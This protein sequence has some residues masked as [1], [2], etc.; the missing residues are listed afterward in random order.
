MTANP[1]A[2]NA[3]RSAAWTLCA[4]LALLA[5][6]PAAADPY[7]AGHLV[8]TEVVASGGVSARGSLELLHVARLAGVGTTPSFEAEGAT[9]EWTEGATEGLAIRAPG[10][11]SAHT[12]GL[13]NPDNVTG[14]PDRFLRHHAT[15]ESGEVQ[16]QYLVHLY[17]A[18]ALRYSATTSRLDTTTIETAHFNRVDGIRSWQPKDPEHQDDPAYDFKEFKVP[19]AVTRSVAT[20]S[21]QITVH[22]TFVVE[23]MGVS[24]VIDGDE[25]KRSV[26]SGTRADP[27]APGAP[28]DNAYNE[29]RTFIRMWVRDGSATFGSLT[30][31]TQWA[32]PATSVTA[33]SAT[34]HAATGTLDTPTGETLEV[35]SAR[36]TIGSMHDLAMRPEEGA[37]G[38]DVTGLD[39]EGH[40]LPPAGVAA[41]PI[42]ASFVGAVFLVLAGLAAIAVGAWALRRR[43]R[44]EPTLAEVEAALAGGQYRKAARDAALILHRKPGMETAMISRAIALSKAGRNERVVAE[45]EGHLRQSDPSDGVLH[46]VLGVAYSDLGRATQAQAAF[47]EALARTPSLLPEVRARLPTGSRSPAPSSKSPAET[48]GYA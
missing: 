6:S 38:V 43:L 31:D 45:V 23:I 15:F 12:A 47:E 18:S 5:V 29:R 22:G 3:P 40:P 26:E 11:A 33:E 14:G 16:T 39:A 25:G 10:G 37:V 13:V 19:H 44:H 28:S 21:T 2:R 24:G 8:A 20:G 41:P 36:Y 17:A 1:I 30:N 27:L 7:V 4:A 32:G 42:P 9:I 35:N 34:L 46:Y 48:H